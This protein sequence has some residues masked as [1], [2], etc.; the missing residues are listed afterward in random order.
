MVSKANIFQAPSLVAFFTMVGAGTAFTPGTAQNVP[1]NE[2][3]AIH[4]FSLV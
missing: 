1:L 4:E 2:S 3:L